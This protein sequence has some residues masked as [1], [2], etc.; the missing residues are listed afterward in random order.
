MN[1]W[2]VRTQGLR[3][4]L[5]LLCRIPAR[6]VL[7]VLLAGVALALP[8]ASA[9]LVQPWDALR[10]GVSLGPEVNLFL[11]PATPEAEI[12]RLQGQLAGRTAVVGVD[13]ITRDSALK[14][15]AQRG[16][17]GPLGDLKA[18]LLP[19]VLVVRFGLGVEPAALQTAVAELRALPR[20]ESVAA[21]V[22]WHRKLSSVLA[23]AR[24]AV[25]ALSAG[26]LGLVVL[27]VLGAVSL[28][29]TERRE[30]LRLLLLVGA[31]DR[32]IVRPFAYAGALTLGCAF[33]LALGLS[34]VAIA[35]LAPL[36]A[37][38]G[39]AYGL[40]IE[41]KMLPLRWLA[42]LAVAALA[43]GGLLGSLVGRRALRSAQR[44][45]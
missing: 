10:G 9:P 3:E 11:A 37:V 32:Y 5:R 4:A 45:A 34:A 1:A 8:L 39:E 19:D 28:P 20:V 29:S 31:D 12:R 30:D 22:V 16:G 15:L 43:F 25:L 36:A 21:D 23:L 26:V 24:S 33:A 7:A 35:A 17:A 13:W 18:S 6:F 27:A 2:S 14:A 41:V 38:M 44:T 40:P 42:S